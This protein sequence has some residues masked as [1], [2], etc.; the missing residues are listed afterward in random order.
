MNMLMI[1]LGNIKAKT[2]DLVEIIS[3]N[4]KDKNSIESMAKIGEMI[5]YE[6]LTG[7]N[8]SIRRTVV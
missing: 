6:I 3:P 8:S 5:P 2:F 7:I 4:K 1:N